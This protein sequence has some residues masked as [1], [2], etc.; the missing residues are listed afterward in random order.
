[1]CMVG[2]F[3]LPVWLL[4]CTCI[5]RMG[6]VVPTVAECE[7]ALPEGYGAGEAG[8]HTRVCPCFARLNEAKMVAGMYV[9]CM[10]KQKCTFTGIVLI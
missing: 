7:R 5:G 2:L 8:C 6:G 4:V 9:H 3:F 10:H 1:M